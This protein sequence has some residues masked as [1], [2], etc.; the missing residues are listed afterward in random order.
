MDSVYGKNIRNAWTN[1]AR[2]VQ[3]EVGRVTQDKTK[4]G[5]TKVPKEQ[6]VK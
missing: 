5:A 4:I 3:F 1:F 2:F 6:K